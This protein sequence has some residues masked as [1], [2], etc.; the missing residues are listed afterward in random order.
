MTGPQQWLR[1]YC[2]NIKKN[3]PDADHREMAL[4]WICKVPLDPRDYEGCL[5][6]V[7]EFFKS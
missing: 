5:K 4:E 3:A 7:D 6:I 1:D 2:R